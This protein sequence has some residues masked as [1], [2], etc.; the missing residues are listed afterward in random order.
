MCT[1]RFGG[2]DLDVNGLLQACP[3]P[4]AAVHRKG[5]SPVPQRANAS[6]A[7]RSVISVGVSN[8]EFSDLPAQIGD[9]LSFAQQ[10][11]AYL[12]RLRSFP[13]VERVVLDFAVEDRPGFS[14]SDIFPAELLLLLGQAGIDLEVTRYAS[15]AATS[16]L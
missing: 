11:A 16:D 6:R 15:G 12:P 5:S 1:L 8:A 2:A 10:H 9:A 14:Q 4:I 7:V 13:G 3:L